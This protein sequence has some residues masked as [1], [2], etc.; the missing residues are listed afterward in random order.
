MKIYNRK[1][2]R[3][4]QKTYRLIWK[5]VLINIIIKFWKNQIGKIGGSLILIKIR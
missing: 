3:N 5:K 1:G 2:V 4:L